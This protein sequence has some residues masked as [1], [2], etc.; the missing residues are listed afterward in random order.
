MKN[1]KPTSLRKAMVRIMSMIVFVIVLLLV[2]LD[3]YMIQSYREAT[4]AEWKTAAGRYADGIKSDLDELDSDLYDIY[5]YDSNYE[6]LKSVRGVE[7][8]PLVYAL[9][10]RL[11]TQLLLKRRAC[12]YVLFFD[13]MQKKRYF[14]GRNT[15]SNAEMEELKQKS[16]SFS[17]MDTTLRRWFYTV[18]QDKEY[19]MGIYR[20]GGVSLVVIYSL[21]DSIRELENEL[22]KTGAEVFLE[23]DGKVLGSQEQ[24]GRFEG[25]LRYQ[26]E[27]RDGVY[28]YERPVRGTGLSLH[29]A[30]PMKI[31]TFINAQQIMVVVIVLVVFLISYLFYRHL[32]MELFHPMEDLVEDMRRIGGGDWSS[33]IHTRSRFTEVQQVIETTDRMIDEIESQ[34]LLAYEKTIQE[35]KARMQYL[36]LQLNPHFYLNGLKTLNFLAMKGD[37]EKLQE[38]IILLSSYL[39]YLLQREDE[40]VSLEQEVAFTKA[41]IHLYQTMT[42]RKIIVEWRVGEETLDCPIPRLCIQ[43]F[44]ENSF[45]YA[46]VGNVDLPLSLLIT[47]SRFFSEEREYLEILIRDNGEGYPDELLTV[48]N[49]APAEGGCSV[50]INNLKRRCGFLYKEDVQFAF[51]NDGGAVSDVFFPIVKEQPDA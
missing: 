14:F 47:T 18:V 22:G 21:E 2:L 15:F 3:G 44:V 51:Y 19:G 13:D 49:E 32:N 36:S 5:S 37:N 24:Q 43:T 20:D 29:L 41:Y 7:A 30:V 4:K 42:D 11:Q 23:Y 27:E 25:M 9:E 33:G 1:E 39:R 31:W 35:Q 48:L 34:K 46:K 40:M 16:E 8:L 26:D 6:K 10:D 28:Y 50:G 17:A 12:G 45:K 38:I